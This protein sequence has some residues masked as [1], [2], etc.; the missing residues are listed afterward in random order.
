MANEIPPVLYSQ[1]CFHIYAGHGSENWLCQINKAN[2][3]YLRIVTCHLHP[4]DSPSLV[5]SL[6][7]LARCSHISLTIE[8]SMAS[9]IWIFGFFS[10]SLFENLHGFANVS[11]TL[12]P[13][14]QKWCN[15][16]YSKTLE[17]MKRTLDDGVQR[18]LSP[19]PRY[20]GIHTEG[21]RSQATVSMHVIF[22]NLHVVDPAS[23][24]VSATWMERS[25][26]A[27]GL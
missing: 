9:W 3:D 6:K 23:Y 7:L 4:Q 27:H 14:N 17:I 20:C 16:D 5:S 1:T 12:H 21:E 11:I 13:T 15:P 18:M 10:Q 2:R 8:T 19:C 26:L 22:P 25:D 24:T